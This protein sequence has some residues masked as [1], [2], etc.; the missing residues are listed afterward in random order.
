MVSQRKPY[1]R[2]ERGHQGPRDLKKKARA[3]W[4]ARSRRAHE[5]ERAH[6]ISARPGVVSAKRA[7][8]SNAARESAPD[9]GHR[10]RDKRGDRKPDRRAVVA[11]RSPSAREGFCSPR[12][13]ECDAEAM[14]SVRRHQDLSSG[15]MN[16]TKSRV[17]V[18]SEGRG[19]PHAVRISTTVLRKRDVYALSE[20]AAVLKGEV[21]HT[22]SAKRP[23]R[24]TRSTKSLESCGS[25]KAA[26]A[27]RSTQEQ[28]P[29]KGVCEGRRQ[30]SF[31]NMG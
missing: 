10:S 9:D 15:G 3:A 6:T 20:Q 4:S 2:Y 25:K 11:D 29:Q 5:Q 30:V 24:R 28:R 12:H 13:E 17:R 1:R 16:G 21:R 7:R 27:R 8:T 18:V 31:G 23:P 19:R 14:A 26:T 22:R